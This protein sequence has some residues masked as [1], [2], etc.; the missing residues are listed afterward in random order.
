MDFAATAGKVNVLDYLTTNDPTTMCLQDEG[1]NTPL[2]NA[3]FRGHYDC[4]KLLLERQPSAHVVMMKNT[5][6]STVWHIAAHMGRLVILRLLYQAY[7]QGVE[8]LNGANL[9]PLQI[10]SRRGYHECLDA[11][12]SYARSDRTLRS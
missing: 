8:E 4:V 1:G 9:S 5:E 6:G 7:P 12:R 2:H 3:C 10:A 11:L